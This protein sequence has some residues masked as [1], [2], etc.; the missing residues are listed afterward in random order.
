MGV[1]GPTGHKEWRAP[2]RWLAVPGTL[3]CHE[4]E[5]EAHALRVCSHRVNAIFHPKLHL[6]GVDLRLTAAYSHTSDSTTCDHGAPIDAYYGDS[7]NQKSGS[8]PAVVLGKQNALYRAIERGKKDL[9]DSSIERGASQN[10]TTCSAIKTK[11]QMVFPVELARMCG[12]EGIEMLE[13]RLILLQHLCSGEV[14]SIYLDSI[15]VRLRLS[16]T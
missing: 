11:G 12:F 8:C 6:A 3:L 2:L 14:T 9:V 16:L 13:R 10:L 5:N 1:P 4:N 15:I 7:T